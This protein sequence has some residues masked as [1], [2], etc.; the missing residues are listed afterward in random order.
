MVP[1]LWPGDWALTVSARSLRRG[2][3][4]V[5]RRPE[6]L[7]MVKRLEGV[8]GDRLDGRVLG[9]DEWWV[10]GEHPSSVDSRT[11]GPVTRAAIRGR[12]AFVYWPPAHR[13]GFP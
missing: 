8:P 9:A 5:V 6:G 10:V 12:L 7:E 1:T 2:D 4:V 11:F 13:R 3:L